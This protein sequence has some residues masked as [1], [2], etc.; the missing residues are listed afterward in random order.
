MGSMY[1]CQRCILASVCDD[2]NKITDNEADYCDEQ[3]EFVNIGSIDALPKLVGIH[4]SSISKKNIIEN[5][6][7]VKWLEMSWYRYTE[8]CLDC[9]YD[10][11]ANGDWHW[12]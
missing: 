1:V 12:V 8:G 3:I 5:L 2:P 10:E 9:A 4:S 7:E 6:K 11:Y